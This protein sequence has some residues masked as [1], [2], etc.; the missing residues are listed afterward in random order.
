MREKLRS[1]GI[2]PLE[3]CP[4]AYFCRSYLMKNGFGGHTV[5]FL[6]SRAGEL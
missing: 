1:H 2:D 3:M 4:G 5:S 6:W